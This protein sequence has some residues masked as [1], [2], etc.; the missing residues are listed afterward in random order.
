MTFGIDVAKY[1][2]PFDYRR[3]K[4]EGVQF[5][6]VKAGGYNTGSLYVAGSYPEHV[7]AARAEGLKIGHYFIPGRGDVQTQADYFVRNLHNFD[8][9]SDVLALDNEPLDGNKVYWSQDNVYTFLSRV[10]KL[11]GIPW[12]RFWVYSPASLTRSNGPWD[13]ITNTGARVWWAAYG[14]GPSGK[15]PDHAPALNGK[16][17]RWDIHQYSSSVKIAGCV[18]DGNYS[19]HDIGVLFG[20]GSA[21]SAVSSAA[22]SVGNAPDT[23]TVNDGIPGPRFWFLMQLWA[24]IYGGYAGP[25]DSVMGVQSWAGVQRNLARESGYTGPIDGVPGVNTYKA[26]QRWA[27]SHGYTGPIDGA[28]GV[29]TWKAVA[30]ALN[31]L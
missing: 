12:D 14:G 29:N 23:E 16:I 31:T 7:D 25:I 30:K 11:L 6:I 22:I 20:G 21:P 18:V 19:S 5:V 1:Q 4:A 26:V 3:A 2:H 15:T 8:V 9:G 28:P 17:A 10:H 27:S 13:K 24:K